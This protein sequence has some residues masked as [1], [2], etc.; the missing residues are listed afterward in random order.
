MVFSGSALLEKTILLTH[1][2]VFLLV[3]LYDWHFTWTS[4]S[5]TVVKPLT[6]TFCV[7]LQC[8]FWDFTHSNATFLKRF[9]NEAYIS[10]FITLATTHRIFQASNMIGQNDYLGSHFLKPEL[11]QVNI[12]GWFL[13]CSFTFNSYFMQC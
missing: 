3:Q 8:N 4:A 2:F 12:F 13:L 10:S 6:L 7:W 9:V 5:W 11:F 1:I